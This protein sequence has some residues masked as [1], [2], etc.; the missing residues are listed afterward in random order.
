MN[1][2]VFLYSQDFYFLLCEIMYKFSSTI[3]VLVLDCPDIHCGD[4]YHFSTAEKFARTLVTLFSFSPSMKVWGCNFVCSCGMSAY[5][6]NVVC[7]DLNPSVVCFYHHHFSV[8]LCQLQFTTPAILM[9]TLPLGPN[10]NN[11]KCKEITNVRLIK[12]NLDITKYHNGMCKLYKKKIDNGSKYILCVC[13][14]Y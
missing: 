2:V 4:M 8:A 5:Y 12:I 1:D 11:N 7:R 14:I 10:C 13:N 3:L 6:R 9:L